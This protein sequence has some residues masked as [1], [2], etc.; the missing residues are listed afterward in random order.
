VP[1]VRKTGCV[2][3]NPVLLPGAQEAIP[4]AGFDP[5]DQTGRFL[6]G[7]GADGRNADQVLDHG[8]K[9]SVRKCSPPG[10]CVDGSVLLPRDGFK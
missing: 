5:L 7:Q 10:E 8:I 3:R 1:V 6:P 4:L 9:A 2:A